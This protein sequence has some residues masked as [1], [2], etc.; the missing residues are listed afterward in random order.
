VGVGG[1]AVMELAPPGPQGRG[2]HLSG[3]GRGGGGCHCRR[4]R[5]GGG[6]LLFYPEVRRCTGD[7]GPDLHAGMPRPGF[8]FNSPCP[9]CCRTPRAAA[10]RPP[11][12]DRG[13]GR[14]CGGGGG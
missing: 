2:G 8:C 5:R 14:V 3:A 9:L 1:R 10:S 7:P 12:P 4:R 13:S 11:G 6:R